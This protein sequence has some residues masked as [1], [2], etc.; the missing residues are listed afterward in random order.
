M[1]SFQFFEQSRDGK[2]FRIPVTEPRR[3]VIH[4]GAKM[5]GAQLSSWLATWG[6]ARRRSSFC[7][8]C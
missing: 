1:Y 2:L 8:W 6:S 7:E 5:A 4:E 3:S